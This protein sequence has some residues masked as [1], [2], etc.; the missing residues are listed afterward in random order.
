MPNLLMPNYV[1]SANAGFDRGQALAFNRLAGMAAQ[2]PDQRSQ[3]LGQAA[4]IDPAGAMQLQSGYARQAR[5]QQTDALATQQQQQ[6]Q[7][8]DVLKK[9]GGAARY[10]LAAVHT[11]NPAQIQ[12]AWSAISPYL[13]QFTGKPVPAQFDPSMLPAMYQ[14]IAQTQQ[15]FPDDA[16]LQTVTPGAV[17][18]RG[19]VPVF[20]N[21]AQAKIVNGMAVTQGT[22]GS[23]QAAPIPIA[24]ASAGAGGAP[25]FSGSATS[26]GGQAVSFDFPPGTPPEVIAAA[27]AAAVAHGDLAPGGDITQQPPQAAPMGAPATLGDAI[28]ASKGAGDTFHTLTPDEV[29]AAGLPGGTIA[30]RGSNGKLA[31]VQKGDGSFQ[32]GEVA[33]PGDPTKTGAE[34]VATLE[35]AVRSI[36]TGLLDGTKPWPTGTVLK[37]PLWAQAVVAAQQADPGF[38]AATYQQR[39]KGR[40]QFTTGKQGDMLRQLRTISMHA[41]QYTRD[42]TTLNNSN[43]TPWNAIRNRGASAFGAQAPGN[44]DTDALALSEEVSKFLTGGVPA[45]TTINEWKDA[46]GTNASRDQQIARATRVIGIVGGQ[47]ASLVQQYKSAMGP[48]SAPLAVVN[49]EAAAAFKSLVDAAQRFHVALPPHV[50]AL[51]SELSVPTPGGNPAT[52]SAQPAAGGGAVDALLGKYGVQ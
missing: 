32:G 50:E 30:Q 38:N 48:V 29:Q 18:T 1:Q 10:M 27:K 46:L 49:P 16:K 36:V 28:A 2:N 17:L 51:Q 5:Q 15:A 34:Y 14:V 7:Q 40:Q 24:G 42:V 9:V 12:G 43:F 11:K 23:M 13:T 8:M 21:P 33:M 45:V 22:D 39:A 37:N 19:G 26:P 3:L 41:D 47:L 6:T 4:G 31:V 25:G 52:Q 20:N 44:V 35:P